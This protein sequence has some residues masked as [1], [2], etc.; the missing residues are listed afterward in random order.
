MEREISIAV[1]EYD[2][3]PAGSILIKKADG[4]WYPVDFEILNARNNERLIR[5]EKLPTRMGKLEKYSKRFVKYAKSHFL[6][7]TNQLLVRGLYDKEIDAEQ[8]TQAQDDV[9]A[10]KKDVQTAIKELNIEKEFNE[11]YGNEN[12]LEEYPEV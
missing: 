9:I 12:E 3:A 6:V 7:L 5:L 10:N 2:E 4:K 11:L 1:R 8:I